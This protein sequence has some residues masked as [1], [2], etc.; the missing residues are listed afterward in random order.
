MWDY[1]A[2]TL[3]GIKKE[4]IFGIHVGSGC[5]GKSKKMELMGCLGDY[6]TTLKVTVLTEK[7]SGIGG[8]SSEISKLKGVRFVFMK[9]PSKDSTLNEGLMKEITGGEVIECRA[10]YTNSNV[11]FPQF[12]LSVCLNTMFEVRSNDDGTWRRMKVIDYHSKFASPGEEFTPPPLFQFPINKNLSA[13]FVVWS[14][15]Y[16]SLLVEIAFRTG[17]EVIDCP[18]VLSAS[19]H[20]RQSQDCITRF[21]AEHIVV[22]TNESIGKMHLSGVF[23]EWHSMEGGVRR[24]PKFGEL[25]E[26]VNLKYGERRRIRGA[27]RTTRWA[28]VRLVQLGRSDEDDSSDGD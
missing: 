15:I 24:A 5:N 22:D 17:G 14:P 2:S 18:E 28:G 1:D 6:Q 9:E 8:T 26:A 25:E 23:K 12:S 21:M 13:R 3:I 16:L 4:N 11:F 27:G 20:Y 10:L 19:T 7:A